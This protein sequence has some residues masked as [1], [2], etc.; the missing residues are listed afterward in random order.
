MV[1]YFVRSKPLLTQTVN[2]KTVIQR[3]ENTS[4]YQRA[5]PTQ[6][7]THQHADAI[8]KQTKFVDTRTAEKV[9]RYSLII[10]RD[11]VFFPAVPPQYLKKCNL[12]NR[13]GQKKS[14]CKFSS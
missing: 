7:T 4:R 10:T 13:V 2:V 3:T 1:Y 12:G 11:S 14:R 6:Q 9:R 8:R 5:P